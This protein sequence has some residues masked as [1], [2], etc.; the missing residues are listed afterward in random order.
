MN[1]Q[2]FCDWKMIFYDNKF[3]YF[4]FEKKIWFNVFFLKCSW[5]ANFFDAFDARLRVHLFNEI[6]VSSKFQISKKK[7][8]HMLTFTNFCSTLKN[9][10]NRSRM[11]KTSFLKCFSNQK[12]KII[13]TTLSWSLAWRFW[14]RRPKSKEPQILST[15]LCAI[16]R[17][18]RVNV[19]FLRI[20]S[21]IINRDVW[22]DLCCKP[23]DELEYI[24]VKQVGR[25]RLL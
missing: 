12:M 16:L 10:R 20:S 22:F 6:F 14:L 1:P 25:K 8:W 4:A 15:G 13:I 23:F 21:R 9:K 17:R 24:I 18:W 7:I 3:F 2:E 5:F 11:I 19:T